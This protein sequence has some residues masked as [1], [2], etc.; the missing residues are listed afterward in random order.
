[1]YQGVG[2]AA[3]QVTWSMFRAG[4]CS[5]REPGDRQAVQS[6]SQGEVTHRAW[7]RVP[8]VRPRVSAPNCRIWLAVSFAYRTSWAGRA[9]FR[10]DCWQGQ[11]RCYFSVRVRQPDV[12]LG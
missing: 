6:W 11:L 10:G 9:L 12:S 7:T 1:M 4:G 2:P 5:P 8:D 3:R